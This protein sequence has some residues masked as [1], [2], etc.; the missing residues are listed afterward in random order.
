MR[1][2]ADYLGSHIALIPSPFSS[3]KY[4]KMQI[5]KTDYGFL[6]S[7]K[8]TDDKTLYIRRQLTSRFD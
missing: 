5:E 1:H 3:D 6:K 2:S 4:M 7:D 8:Q